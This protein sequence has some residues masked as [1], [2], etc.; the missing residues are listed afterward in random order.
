MWYNFCYTLVMKTAISIP[1]DVYESA[2]KLANRLGKSRSQLYTQA[3][4][5]YVAKHNKDNVT[6]M[7]DEVYGISS[8]RL[9][10]TLRS[11][12]SKSLPRENW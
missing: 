9:D 1:N 5:G 2:E 10:D 12:Q 7:L 3:L 4:S 6:S 8:S 11:L